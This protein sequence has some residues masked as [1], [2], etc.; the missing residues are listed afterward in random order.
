MRG[1]VRLAPKRRDEFAS[2][3]LQLGREAGPVDARPVLFTQFVPER[4]H[5]FGHR[6]HAAA[7]HEL[8][9]AV[10][11]RPNAEAIEHQRAD[12]AIEFARL[13]L[14]RLQALDCGG[15]RCIGGRAGRWLGQRNVSHG[16]FPRGRAMYIITT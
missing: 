11:R 2:G 14:R 16:R 9:G 13:R 8:V 5:D 15:Q 10:R 1:R 7:L 3:L 4:V 12:V 6:R